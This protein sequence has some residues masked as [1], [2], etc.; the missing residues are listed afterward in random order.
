MEDIVSARAGVGS[1]RRAGLHH[2]NSHTRS[3]DDHR[4]VAS[5][6]RTPSQAPTDLAGEVPVHDLCCAAT[7]T[8][9]NIFPMRRGWI[10]LIG[11]PLLVAGCSSFFGSP[12]DH[13]SGKITTTDTATAVQETRD[14]AQRAAVSL[15]H[16]TAA[17][18]VVR[19]SFRSSD[20]A[21]MRLS[22][23]IGDAAPGEIVVTRGTQPPP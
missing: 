13:W 6:R 14:C 23:C 18:G 10:V 15:T 12:S 21:S 4:R 5:R 9:A 16:L 11:L 22:D 3:R 17:S 20:R 1:D 8:P 7:L 19:F 2:P